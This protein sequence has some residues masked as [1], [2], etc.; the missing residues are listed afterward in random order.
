MLSL[1]P[2]SIGF[3][4]LRTR[5][6]D[7]DVL[8]NRALVYTLLTASLVVVYLGAVVPLQY[9]SWGFVGET[10]QLAVVIS[11]LAIAALFSPLRHRIQ[12]LIDRR[13]YREKYD[14][15]ETLE[16]FS[17]TLRDETDLDSLGSDLTAVVRETMRP[18][19]VSLWLR[20]PEDGAR[21]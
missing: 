20:G 21:R 17:A 12:T 19:D 7:V 2:L 16:A 8:I 5:L 11:T 18:E 15:R 6:F 10:S 9:A 14:A 1:I 3:A 13:F 4:V